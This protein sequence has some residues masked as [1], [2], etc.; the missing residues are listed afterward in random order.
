MFLRFEV[1]FT[2]KS[3][4]FAQDCLH[5]DLDVCYWIVWQGKIFLFSWSNKILFA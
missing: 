5:D 2:Q 1:T 4:A 3:G